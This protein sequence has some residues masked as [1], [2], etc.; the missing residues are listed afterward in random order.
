MNI[1]LQRVIQR[2]VR[3]GN[4]KVTGPSGTTHEFGDGTGA[5]VHM[6]IKTRRAERAITF[7]ALLA[8]PEAY[9]D[10]DVDLIEGDV[11]GLLKQVYENLGPSATIEGTWLKALE[12]LRYAFRRLYQVNTAAR[13]KR[14]VQHHY[15]LS[16]ELYRLF[17]DE[18][19][20][21]SCAY[22]EHPDMTLEEAQL[23]K[24]R[25]IAAKL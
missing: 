12:G 11:L 2:I 23:A 19:M 25:H 1:L 16:G 14:N 8:L 20:Q 22:F 10:G 4:L 5:P 21:Y 18:D 7:D 3:T 13:A 9:M 17:L 24:K 6:L 15:D